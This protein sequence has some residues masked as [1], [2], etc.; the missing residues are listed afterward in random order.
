MGFFFFQKILAIFE[1]DFISIYVEFTEF[2]RIIFCWESWGGQLV[3]IF[4]YIFTVFEII[5]MR[6]TNERNIVCSVNFCLRYKKDTRDISG[7]K[8]WYGFAARLLNRAA[9]CMN[10]NHK[11]SHAR[12]L[13]APTYPWSVS[14]AN[15]FASS[16]LVM[17]FNN[18]T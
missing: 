4:H 9:N 12:V 11:I 7:R 6:W 10:W 18:Y 3:T 14:N 2:V 16:L 13:R 17:F 5:W 8:H 1:K 15:A